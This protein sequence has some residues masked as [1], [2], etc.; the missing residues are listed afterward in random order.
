MT[1]AGLKELAALKNLHTL[2]LIQ[3]RVTGT[4][5]KELATLEELEDLNLQFDQGYGR[6][7][8]GRGH[9][10]GTEVA[11]FL[12]TPPRLRMRV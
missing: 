5:L 2:G 10:Q 1:D 9:A 11:G 12:S 8:E 6:G 3:T 7:A 4:G